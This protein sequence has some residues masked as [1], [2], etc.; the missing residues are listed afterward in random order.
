MGAEGVAEAA[1]DGLVSGLDLTLRAFL[2][3]GRG[4]LLEQV[5][6]VVIELGR[7]LDDDL[8]DQI[9]APGV[10]NANCAMAATSSR[11]TA[12]TGMQ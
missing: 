12:R 10:A 4:Q 7:G 11:V 1:E 6:L 3:A 9:A 2:A 8:D 5:G